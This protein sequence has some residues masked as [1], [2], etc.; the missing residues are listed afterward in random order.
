MDTKSAATTS[1]IRGRE[2]VRRSTYWASPTSTKAPASKQ[3][4]PSRYGKL[5]LH[6]A[7]A[8]RRILIQEWTKPSTS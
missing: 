5:S 7:Q 6:P 3:P 1:F 4:V 2:P 8:R